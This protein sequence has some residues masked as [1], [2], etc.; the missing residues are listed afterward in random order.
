MN[1]RLVAL[2]ALTLTVAAPC[3]GAAPNDKAAQT[4]PTGKAPP[5]R[6][7]PPDLK[8]PASAPVSDVGTRVVPIQDAWDWPAAMQKVTSKFTGT[9][10]VVLHIGDS[11]TYS[12]AYGA[13]ARSGRGKTDSD[14]EILQ[15]M[16]AG[17]NDDTDG[18][19]LAAF[20]VPKR[21]GSH[22]AV[23]GMR[24]VQAL[25][26]GFHGLP[27]MSEIIKKYNPQ[28]VILL[29]GTNDA[30]ADRPVEDF[31]AD[32]EKAVKLILA[33]HTI[34]VL[35]TIP[36][37][38]HKQPLAL[39]YNKA[40]VELARQQKLPLIDLYG[41]ILSRQPTPAWNGT[42]MNKGDV[43][44]SAAY[45]G[46]SPLSEPT[47]DNLAKSGYLLRGWLTVQKS[48]DVKAKAIDPVTH[49]TDKPTAETDKKKDKKKM[50]DVARKVPSHAPH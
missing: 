50:L 5:S 13:W 15:W 41:Q 20:D 7:I 27:A 25:E 33:N 18:W 43:H 22:T 16:H 9:Q 38:I 36:P 40:I 34:P 19:Y 1:P 35:S 11:I 23:S 32:L 37:H 47:P 4:Q 46:A 8:P 10:G 49:K 24:L 6:V 26:G 2:F 45:E 28:V 21:G 14:T 42:L 29:L 44:P 39:E 48:K 31:R 12:N 3:I 30:S 17:A